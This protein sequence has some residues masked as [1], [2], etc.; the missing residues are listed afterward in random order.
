MFRKDVILISQDGSI[1]IAIEIDGKE[2]VIATSELENLESAG[3]DVGKGLKAAE[4]SMSSLSDSSV[5]AAKGVKGASDSL[6]GLGESGVDASKG[7][8]GA[9]GAVDGL[10][11]SAADA[12]KGAQGAAGGL[13]GLGESAEEAAAKAKKLKEEAEGMGN[14]TERASGKTK[15][16]AVSIGLIAIAATAFATLKSSMDAAITRFDTLATFPKVLQALGVSADDSERAM[17][18]LS[19]GIDG[20]PTT[21]NEIASNAQRMY[22]SFNDMDKSTDSALALNNALLGSGSSAAQAQRGTEQYL[23]MLQTGKVEMDSWNTLSETMDV[24]LIKIAEGFDFAGKSAKNDLYKALQDGTITMDQFNDKLIEVG[25][26]TGIMATLAKENSLGLATSIGNLKNAAARG[27][28]NIIES[29]DKLSQNVTGKNIAENIDGLKVIVNAAFKVIG[30]VI[31]GASP[32]VVGFADAV[33]ATIPVVEALAPA[34]IGLMSAYAAYTIITKVSAAIKASNAILAVATASSNALALATAASTTASGADTVAKAAQAGMVSLS[35]LAIGVMTGK[36]KLSTAAQVIATAV[37]YGFGAAVKFLMGPVGWVVAGIG[38]LVAGTIALVKWLKKSSEESKRLN[39][40]TEELAQAN[41]SLNES[42]KS[43]TD[44]YKSNQDGIK[45]T[46]KA[47]SDLARK[48]DELSQKEN[49]SATDKAMLTEYV[50]QLN[51]SV[52]GLNLAYSEEADALNM[53]SIGMRERIDLMSE[54][55]SKIAA[56]ERMVEISKEQ[57]EIDMKLEETNALRAEW[58]KNMDE[59]TVKSGEYKDAIELLDE[60]EVGL[61]ETS[62]ALG[63]QQVIVEEQFET[64]MANITAATA[65][66]VGEQIILFDELSQGQQATVEDMK[67][68]WQ[69]YKDAATDMF[70]VLS[71]EAGLTIDEM[72]ANL[73]EN[74][75]II[76]EWA[77]NIATLAE[78]GVDEGLLETLRAAGPESAGHVKELVNSSDEELK[79]LSDAFSEGGDVATDALSK[80]LGIEESG[81][82]EAIG[83]LVVDTE[84]SLKQ[85]VNDANFDSIGVDVATG[86]SEGIKDGSKDATDAARKMADDTK[87]AAKKALDSHS[88]SREFKKIGLDTTDGYAL[89]INEGTAKV[90][91]AIEKMFR[92]VQTDSS[93]SFKIITKDYDNAVLDIETSL[94]KLP[95]AAQKVMQNVL[96]RLKAGS[97]PQINVMKT[98]AKDLIGAYSGLPAQFNTIGRNVMAGLNQGLL[99]GRGRVLATAR[100]IANSIINTMQSALRIHSPSRAARDEVGKEVPAGVALGIEDNAKTVYRALEQMSS[101][102]ISFSKPEIALGTSR[103]AYAGMSGQ[104]ASNSSARVNRGNQSER[105]VIVIKPSDVNLEGRAVG[106]ITWEV[107]KEFIDRDEAKINRARG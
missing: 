14:E 72:A 17:T 95:E 76:G 71:D 13:D 75:R 51:G 30:N 106:S 8:K 90:I 99:S 12:A 88:P 103:M 104:V 11:D 97:T 5:D 3:K 18:N 55:E 33:K 84:K 79:R 77:T 58:N 35:T 27:I 81:V 42:V 16:F 98:L 89:G 69:D 46:A 20:L 6:E 38:L 73:E 57:N 62:K 66:A 25:T 37:T 60:Q 29:F 61:K 63:E 86:Y 49:K 21:L 23:K 80:S 1:R 53:S 2:L 24:G 43:S 65:T 44:A 26:G 50:E 52:E 56:Q 82:L 67:A 107:V 64:A 68:T 78:R 4:G 10:A 7:L 45:D 100:G 40:D 31:E 32:I 22:T 96:T 85:Q 34:I 54:Q 105:E 41:D 48:I 70:D 19:E 101:N 102:I 59:G 15:K 36:V 83:H 47:N 87:A 94:K 9:D 39:A 91:Q 28:A 92:S 74:Q 93:R